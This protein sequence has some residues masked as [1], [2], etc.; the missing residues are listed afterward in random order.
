M[1]AADT[2]PRPTPGPSRAYRFPSFERLT[3]DNGLRVV[4]APVSKLPIA[5]VVALVDAGAAADPQGREGVA[6]LT[7]RALAEGTERSDGAQLAERFERLGTALDS[8]ADW[9]SATV[10]ITVTTERLPAALALLAEVIREPSF[11]GREVDRLRQERLAE[12]LQQQAEPRGLADD[13]FGKFAYA[14][15]SRYALPD[16]GNESSVE[17][18]NQGAVR[19]F[20]DERYS[21]GST[22][23]IVVGD[24]TVDQARA[25]LA[26]TFGSWAGRSVR[27][28]AVVDRPAATTRIVHVVGK[29]DAPQSELRVGHVGVPRL[30]PEYFPIV[31]MN[32]ILGGL[33]SSRINLNLREAHA[34]TYGAF[35][36]FDWR[37]AAGPF[38]V[39][40]AV[41]SDV[42]DAAVRE[43]LLEIDKLRASGVT[44]A[45]LTLATSYLDG[46]FPI[47]FESTTAIANALASLVSYG[48][49]DD[50]FDTYRSKIRSV[51]ADRV[52]EAARAHLRPDELQIVTVGD[53][54]VV[55]EALE[56]LKVGPVLIYDA[57]GRPAS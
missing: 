39:S 48:L 32:A 27:P 19:A 11:P 10:R 49:P 52:L 50:Y 36:S 21:P 8:S 18:L 53:P 13:M 56:Q 38:T 40:T 41:R 30:H 28:V 45:E 22:T 16:G 35:S 25:M 4:V 29:S 20:Y 24:V 33:F 43:I 42:T 5:T 55:R 1:T 37:R 31:V 54:A 26:D 9:D 47:R 44:D 46:V 14:Q 34:Y 2:I 15:G 23:L 57:E 7:A 6:L 3:L 51:T 12:L 17:A